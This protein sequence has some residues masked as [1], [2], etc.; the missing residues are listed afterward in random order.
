MKTAL[1]MLA[2][3]AIA[4]P[5]ASFAA[6]T[7]EYIIEEMAVEG[8][9]TNS[10]AYDRGNAGYSE[11]SGGSVA[12][13]PQERS[14]GSFFK[15]REGHFRLGVVGPGYAWANKGAGSMMNIGVEGEYFFWEKLSALM[16]VWMAT[17]FTDITIL[18][19]LP[20]ARYVFDFAS[21]PRWSLYVQGGVGLALYNAE[22]AAADIAI[23]G[24]GFWWQWTERLSLGAETQLHILARSN[25]AIGFT[26]APAIR[27][28]F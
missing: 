18:G 27:Y 9:G 3:A 11:S 19:F 1:I 22:S 23:P 13:A 7:E 25:V 6:D 24:V 2:I 28:Q 5:S 10:L 12:P 14:S 16:R 15:T 21:H 17:D 8:S 20:M 4:I 26:V